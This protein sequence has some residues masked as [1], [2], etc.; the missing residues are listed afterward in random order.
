MTPTTD[1][2]GNEVPVMHDRCYDGH[3]ACQLGAAE[4]LANATE[5]WEGRRGHAVPR[6]EELGDGARRM[7]ED[8]DAV[9]QT[10]IS[11]GDVLHPQ[12]CLGGR[13]RSGGVIGR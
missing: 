11:P 13:S 7:V 3:V 6:A 1:Q 5:P 10:N 4:R 9:L 12:R 2:D 8:D